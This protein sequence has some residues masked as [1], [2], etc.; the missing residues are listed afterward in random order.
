[1]P[2]FH[3]LTAAIVWHNVPF[4]ELLQYEA[5]DVFDGLFCV[6]HNSALQIHTQKPLMAEGTGFLFGSF[7]LKVPHQCCHP[8]PGWGFVFGC[9]FLPSACL[10]GD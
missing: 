5:A 1:M 2:L 3:I 6:E 4:A 8:S 9:F 10:E 7:V